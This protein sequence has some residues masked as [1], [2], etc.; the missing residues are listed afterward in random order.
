MSIGLVM[1]WKAVVMAV[2]AAI[3]ERWQAY[4]A[5]RKEQ[6]IQL[7]LDPRTGVYR[8]KVDWP[9]VLERSLRIG[10]NAVYTFIAITWA[11]GIAYYLSGKN[12]TFR[13]WIVWAIFG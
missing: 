2:W 11:V 8:A 7:V 6:G 10:R 5:H 4:R 9:E 1:F 3:V 13:A 12:E